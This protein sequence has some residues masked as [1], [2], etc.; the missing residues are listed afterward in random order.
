MAAA[1]YCNRFCSAG[2]HP[3]IQFIRHGSKA[4]TRHWKAMHIVREKLMAVTKYI[5]PKPPIPVE[6]MKPLVKPVI[7]ENGFTKILRRQVEQTFRENNM[8]AVCQYNYAPGSDIVL[9]RHRLRKYNIHA[10]FFPNEIIIPFLLESKYKNLLPLFVGRNLILVSPETRAKEMLRVLKS[11]PQINL[12]GAC[13]DNTILSKEGVANYAK[14]PSMVAAQGEVVGAL[15]LLT[16]QTS[17]LLQRGPAHLTSLLEQYV[18][19]QSS[20]EVKQG[21]G[22]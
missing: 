19:Q 17:T 6:C 13:I 16:S 3:T 14:L 12:L 15:S 1:G 2:W 11:I 18:K 10:K 4:V 20:E 5:P 22:S 8:I 21:D 7:E 9:M